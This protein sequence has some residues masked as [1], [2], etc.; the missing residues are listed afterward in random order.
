MFTTTSGGYGS[1]TA[2]T[3]NP[4]SGISNTYSGAIANGAANM[5]QNVVGTPANG[6]TYQLGA[7]VNGRADWKPCSGV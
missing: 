7:V 2:L 4:G 1:V 6:W 3:L 5:T